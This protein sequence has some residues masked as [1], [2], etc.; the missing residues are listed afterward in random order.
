MIDT[1]SMFEFALDFSF[2]GY[3]FYLVWNFARIGYHRHVIVHQ[4]YMC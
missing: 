3:K 1:L 4:I 2:T